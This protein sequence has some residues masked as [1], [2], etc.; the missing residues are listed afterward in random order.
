[1]AAKTKPFKERIADII[2]SPY[3]P[4]FLY[5]LGMFAFFLFM[6]SGQSL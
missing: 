1:M 5:A 2:M 6:Q 3:C 4:V